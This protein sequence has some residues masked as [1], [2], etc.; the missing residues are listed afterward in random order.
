MKKTEKGSVDGVI[1]VA[2]DDGFAE[3]NGLIVDGFKI[4]DSSMTSI[5][6]RARSGIHEV[7]SVSGEQELCSCYEADGAKYT[8][9]NFLDS[10]N[11]KFAEY[12]ISP[13]NRVIVHHLLR[14]MGLGGK[15]VRIATGLPM[16]VYFVGGKPNTAFIEKK[17]KSLLQPVSALDGSETAQIV[18]HRVFA[19]GLGAWVDYAVDDEGNLTVS[20]D[21]IVGFIDVGGKTTDSG[22]ILP[23]QK[24]DFAR[25]GSADLGVLN[26]IE[27]LGVAINREFGYSLPAYLVEQSLKTGKIKKF[28]KDVDITALIQA[29]VHP[30]QEAIAR[31]VAR[32]F[33]SGADIW[34][35]LLVGGGANLF[36][37]LRDIYPNI[38]LSDNPGFANAKG[39]GKFL[40]I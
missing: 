15:K 19:E 16:D 12:P 20:D 23:G 34:K 14:K 1:N 11:A 27:A 21:E 37:G 40:S 22:V 3:T 30:V 10:E 24:I 31:E 32:K 2:V 6:T 29:A 26:V 36:V 38:V 18:E 39:F 4:D 28:G 33:G 13:M 7:A 8:V 5:S 17:V 9:G 35:I 25:C